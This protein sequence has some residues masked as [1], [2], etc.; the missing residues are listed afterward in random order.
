MNTKR[1]VPDGRLEKPEDKAWAEWYEKLD[2]SE[3]E[4][5]LAQ[6]GL[7]KEDIEEWEEAEGIKK[8]NSKKK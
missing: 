2:V 5:Y 4:K 8:P 7:D 6:L 3:H 1:K